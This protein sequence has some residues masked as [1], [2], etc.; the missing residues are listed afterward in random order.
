M[1]FIP[2]ILLCSS[3]IAVKD[4]TIDNKNVSVTRGGP[5]NTPMSCLIQGQAQIAQT[6]IAP[7]LGENFY[8]V[9][10]CQIKKE[11]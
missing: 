2:I 9:I 3:D 4:C 10:K 7:T 5:Q 11:Y 8:V 6:A 1:K